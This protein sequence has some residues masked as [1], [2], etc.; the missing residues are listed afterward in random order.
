MI[1]RSFPIFLFFF[2][3]EQLP[4]VNIVI[5]WMAKHRVKTEYLRGTA[6]TDECELLFAKYKQCLGVSFASLLLPSILENSQH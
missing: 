1:F 3:Q 6:T 4:K 2:S 5:Q